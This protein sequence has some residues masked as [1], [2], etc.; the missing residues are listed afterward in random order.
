MSTNASSRPVPSNVG[1]GKRHSL[2]RGLVQLPFDPAEGFSCIG[3]QCPSTNPRKAKIQTTVGSSVISPVL[4]IRSFSMPVV[5]PTRMRMIAELFVDAS[6][7]NPGWSGSTLAT[8]HHT[9]GLS[10]RRLRHQPRARRH[11]RILN[12]VS[13]RG[14]AREW[15]M[16]LH[17][18]NIGED[19]AAVEISQGVVAP[20]ICEGHLDPEFAVSMNRK[21]GRRVAFAFGV[22]FE[23]M[24]T[25]ERVNRV[26]RPRQ[27]RD[28]PPV[29]G[30]SPREGQVDRQFTLV[31]SLID[32]PDIPG[33]LIR[34][35]TQSPSSLS[36][37]ARIPPMRNEATSGKS[38]I[39]SS[40]PPGR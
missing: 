25:F 30:S 37:R 31:D 36:E 22:D 27:L 32:D 20:D 18:S 12:A 21:P 10:V 28:R 9:G 4:P 1:V 6:I 3:D 40:A 33:G 35:F 23:P 7:D 26:V 17:R 15:P 14:G 8:P 5:A 24:R 13:S 19:L 39:V 2:V 16:I 34:P 29:R 38:T 11:V